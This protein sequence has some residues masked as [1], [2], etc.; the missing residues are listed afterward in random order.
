MRRL[1]LLPVLA[2]A[3]AGSAS[4]SHKAT[5]PV[6]GKIDHYLRVNHSPLAGLGGAFMDAGRNCKAHPF[7]GRLLPAIAGEESEFGKINFHPHNPFGYGSFS[8]P[9]YRQA[10][11]K[12]AH[13]LC[14]GYLA[15]GLNTISAI[16]HV[17]APPGINDPN[18]T[19]AG[20]PAAVSRFFAAMGGRHILL[21][22]PHAGR[23]P[24]RHKLPPP[25]TTVKF[26]ESGPRVAAIQWLAAG[27]SRYHVRTYKGK[28]TGYYGNKTRIAVYFLKFRLGWPK[29]QGKLA[30]P[31]LYRVL[32]GSIPRPLGWIRLA[33]QRATSG[34][35]GTVGSGNQS[36]VALLASVERSQIGVHEAPWGSNSSPPCGNPRAPKKAC[37]L[38]YQAATT[39]GG[40]N[41]PWCA[42]LQA[43]ALKQI[44]IT[45]YGERSAAVHTVLSWAHAR[46]LVHA[47]PRPG[48]LVAFIWHNAGSETGSHIGFVE[49]VS[50]GGFWTDIEGNESDQVARKGRS[51]AALGGRSDFW[52]PFFMT[53]RR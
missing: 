3:L 36:L 19:N 43:W 25:W 6:G 8:W 9:N 31:T 37:V 15:H 39:L 34:T 50:K 23:A 53:V 2:L 29:P 41:W 33:G 18:G 26:G 13:G 52:G 24:K 20:W 47:L 16:A 28:P 35:P 22:K 7:D 32:L 14:F 51:F 38:A 1:F 48:D 30:G 45:N 49:S 11:A 46:G 21:A 12:V 42:A 40:S 10:I 17:W 4:A 27:N 44:G 5:A